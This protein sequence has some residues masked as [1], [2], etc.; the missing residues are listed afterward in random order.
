MEA[1]LDSLTL[2]CTT[3]THKKLISPALCYTGWTRSGGIPPLPFST[4]AQPASQPA[5]ETASQPASLI[6]SIRFLQGGRGGGDSS[7]NDV[8]E[9]VCSEWDG[10]R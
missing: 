7:A 3:Q 8:L 10:G 9:G 1:K 4:G 6:G 2:S 5:S